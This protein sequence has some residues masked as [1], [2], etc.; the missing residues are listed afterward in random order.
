[1]QTSPG[2]NASQLVD[3]FFSVLTYGCVVKENEKTYES[4]KFKS[5]LYI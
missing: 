2:F 3:F 1:M 5:S 4:Q